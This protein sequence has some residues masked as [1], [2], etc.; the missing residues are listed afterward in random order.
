[1]EYLALIRLIDPNLA[2]DFL[3]MAA[4]LM[5]IKSRMLLPQAEKT[6]G[7][8]QEGDPRIE[9]IRQLME[10][11]KFKEAAT[12]L[13]ER[14]EEQMERFGRGARQTFDGQ[15]EPA[16]TVD[17]SEVSIWDILSAFERMMRQTLRLA[18]AAIIDRDV[19]VGQ[20]IDKI[21]RMLRVQGIVTFL[22]IFETCEDRLDALGAL[23]AILEM[24]RAKVVALDQS[25]DRTTITIKLLSEAGVPR[26]LVEVSE[27]RRRI[28]E[29]VEVSASGE[30]A[31][32]EDES[33]A[34]P[35]GPPEAPPAAAPPDEPAREEET[36]EELEKIR[37]ITVHEVELHEEPTDADRAAQESADN[38]PMAPEGAS[39]AENDSPAREGPNH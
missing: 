21:L 15:D 14:R 27:H 13:A 5:E 7:E 11:K 10:Y 28:D 30:P 1:M 6:E 22:T 38:D 12:M 24:A 35:A 17:M 3:V 20:Q 26:L 36:D 23:L 37:E 8:E 32:E 25:P 29:V 33:A 31:R 16:G 2:G 9:L 19:P 4:T 39:D 18:P 34:E